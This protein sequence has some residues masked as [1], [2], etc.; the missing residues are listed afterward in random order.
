MGLTT[1]KNDDG[2]KC[3]CKLSITDLT[4]LIS[5]DYSISTSTHAVKLVPYIHVAQALDYHVDTAS[6]IVKFMFNTGKFVS[7]NKF[8]SQKEKYTLSR[9]ILKAFLHNW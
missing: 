2:E 1:K 5:T 3:Q 7:Q 6:I 4:F 8:A 9:K